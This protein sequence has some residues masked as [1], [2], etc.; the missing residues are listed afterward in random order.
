MLHRLYRATNTVHQCTS[1][2][3]AE[4]LGNSGHKHI[5][6]ERG[7]DSTEEKGYQLRI[8]RR[9]FA[10]T[11]QTHEYVPRHRS[12]VSCDEAYASLPVDRKEGQ[13]PSR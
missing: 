12:A 3:K 2:I 5:K 13:G 6:Q 1:Q 10:K 4:S 9:T 7:M 8:K 11:E